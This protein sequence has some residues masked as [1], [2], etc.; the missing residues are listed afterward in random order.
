MTLSISHSHQS[1]KIRIQ[2]EVQHIVHASVS[3]QVSQRSICSSDL[4]MPWG[5]WTT[6]W[7]V[8]SQHIHLV[9]ANMFLQNMTESQS[10]IFTYFDEWHHNAT[11]SSSPAHYIHSVTL[12]YHISS[13]PLTAPP[14]TEEPVPL[15][16]H[17]CPGYQSGLQTALHRPRLRSHQLFLYTAVQ[18]FAVWHDTIFSSYNIFPYFFLLLIYSYFKTLNLFK[19]IHKEATYGHFLLATSGN[20][21]SLLCI[22]ELLVYFF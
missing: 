11:S 9:A 16:S 20:H 4:C 14:I 1:L 10:S 17:S 8:A 21:P 19:L 6:H 12:S 5:L 2:M 7:D 15:L 22:Y 3:A 13:S 18:W